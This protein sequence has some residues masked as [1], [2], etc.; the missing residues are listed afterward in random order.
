MANE[1]NLNHFTSIDAPTGSLAKQVIGTRYPAP[2]HAAL[3]AM[4]STTRQAFIRAAV[5]EKLE[6]I[7]R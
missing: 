6:A 5:A 7:Y 1:Q 4:E 3:M 2:V